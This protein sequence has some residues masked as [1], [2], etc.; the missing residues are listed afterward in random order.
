[1]AFNLKNRERESF[2]PVIISMN[3]P[4]GC[5]LWDTVGG[6]TCN[7]ILDF[8]ANLSKPHFTMCKLKL[9][10]T[11]SK[12]G[13]SILNV[14]WLVK[15]A[16]GNCMARFLCH[17]T[18]PAS[19]MAFSAGFPRRYRWLTYRLLSQQRAGRGHRLKGLPCSWGDH[20]QT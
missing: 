5:P 8:Q 9:V 1:M 19:Q 7:G 20:S 4:A 18:T 11:P 15:P 6:M 16:S 17:R 12:I 13:F 10:P 14:S 2:K 3:S